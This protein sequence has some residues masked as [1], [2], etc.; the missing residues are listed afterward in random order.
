MG[1]TVVF[2]V[3]EKKRSLQ[4]LVAVVEYQSFAKEKV[5]L[6]NRD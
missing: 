4:T 3:L 6:Q 5:P 2:S 1:L